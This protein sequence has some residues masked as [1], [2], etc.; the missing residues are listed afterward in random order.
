MRAEGDQAKKA[1]GS[2][3]LCACLDAG[4]EG[5]THDLGK[6]KREMAV[7]KGRK[8]NAGTET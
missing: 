8:N 4:I 3:Q 7:Q 5:A 1:F 2:L 6:R